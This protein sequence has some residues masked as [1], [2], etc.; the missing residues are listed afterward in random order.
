MTPLEQ[1]I[2]DLEE[3]LDATGALP[4]YLF[5]WWLRGQGRGLTEDQIGELCR[6]AYCELR[7]RLDLRLVWLDSPQDDPETG[8]PALPDTDPDFDLNTTGETTGPV[9]TLVPSA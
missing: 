5:S 1:L 7:R 3:H 4:V 8:T 6:T 9:L 2:D